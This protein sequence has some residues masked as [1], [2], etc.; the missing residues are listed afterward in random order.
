[1][2]SCAATADATGTLD[3][4]TS[5]RKLAITGFDPQG[6]LQNSKMPP[7]LGEHTV[8]EVLNIFLDGV[9]EH[10]GMAASGEEAPLAASSFLKAPTEDDCLTVSDLASPFAARRSLDLDANSAPPTPSVAAAANEPV[11]ASIPEAIESGTAELERSVQEL[12]HVLATSEETCSARQKQC[13]EL[14][15][16]A[17]GT[18]V[19]MYGLRGQLAAAETR[20]DL[21]E[22]RMGH[23]RGELASVR[24]QLEV[25][26]RRPEPAPLPEVKMDVLEVLYCLRSVIRRRQSQ[27]RR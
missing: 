23:L 2:S 7:G 25:A 19:E 3:Y 15:R 9:A 1:M 14:K 17:E 10:L 8:L 22:R 4:R 27:Q 5:I 21:A 24:Q 6:W 26:E 16:A 18:A 11:A 20:A 12:R 13:E